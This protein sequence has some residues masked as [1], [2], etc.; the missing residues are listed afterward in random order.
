[1]YVCMYMYMN[2]IEINYIN[3]FFLNTQFLNFYIWHQLVYYNLLLFLNFQ[4]N[5]VSYLIFYHKMNLK[6]YFF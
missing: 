6:F 5:L 4:L 2:K 1:M 3:I